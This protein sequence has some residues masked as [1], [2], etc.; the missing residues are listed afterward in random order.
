[1]QQELTDIA[2]IDAVLAGDQQAYALLVKR[3][4]RYVFTLALRFTKS[5]EDAEE[6]AQ[7][8][9]VKAFKYLSGYERK[10][11]FTT[12]LYR[13]VYT[14]AMTYLRKKQVDVLSIDDENHQNVLDSHQASTDLNT[15]RKSRDYYL[16]L[17]I[18]SL[19]PDDASIIT[20]FYKGE[21]S[22]EEIAQIMGIEANTAK[23]KL[24]RARGRLKIKLEQLLKS[25]AEDLI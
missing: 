5:R 14:T 18:E 3:Y 13:I 10:G 16:N 11:K 7:D 20:L 15:E 6:V 4:Q 25:E 19:L 24:H 1:M 2:I 22:L 21:Q 23:V 12:W 9:F 17:A 8:C